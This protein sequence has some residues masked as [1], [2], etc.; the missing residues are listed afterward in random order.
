MIIN[1]ILAKYENQIQEINLRFPEKWQSK[2]IDL[3]LLAAEG[4]MAIGLLADKFEPNK[5]GFF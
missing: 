5:L 3:K 2:H 1:E 4:A